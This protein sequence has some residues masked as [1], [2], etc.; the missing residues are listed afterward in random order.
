MVL[1][2]P[3]Y[4]GNIKTRKSQFAYSVFRHLY[5]FNTGKGK[6]VG[7]FTDWTQEALLLYTAL[8]VTGFS[9]NEVLGLFA[10]S[11]IPLICICYWLGWYYLRWNLDKIECQVHSERNP[12]M[13]DLHKRVVKDKGEEY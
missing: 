8:H 12:L 10:I 1:P 7:R 4:P 11:A 2:T 13:N 5:V 3:E 6:V 9:T